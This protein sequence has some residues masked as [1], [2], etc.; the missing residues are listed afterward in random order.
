MLCYIAFVTFPP[1]FS[2]DAN[3]ADELTFLEGDILQLVKEGNV[4]AFGFR[5]I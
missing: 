2:Y 4:K 1:F 5:V 3:D